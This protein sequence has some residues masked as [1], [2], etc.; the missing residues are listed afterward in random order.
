MACRLAPGRRAVCRFGDAAEASSE[1]SSMP[2]AQATS[3]RSGAPRR[4]TPRQPPWARR[5]DEAIA[6]C[7]RSRADRRRPQSEGNILAVLGGLYAMQGAFDHARRPRRSRTSAASRSSVWRWMRPAWAWRGGA[8]RCL[9]A[10]STR[11]SGSCA[12]LRR[13]GRRRRAVASPHRGRALAQ[14]LLAHGAPLDESIPDRPG[15]TLAADVDVASQALWRGTRRSLA[16]R[17]SYGEAEELIREALDLL[18]PTDATMYQLD[19]YLD[20]GEVLSVAGRTSTRRARP[21]SAGAP[22]RS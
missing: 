14:T 13:T 6:R 22:S 16:R 21:I 20:L 18:A 3:A 19:A 5:V 1:P 8:S 9:P 4:P 17:A 15:R 2:G 11:P 12:P 7:G 10:I